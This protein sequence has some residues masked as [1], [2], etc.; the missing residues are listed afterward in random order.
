MK[1][2]KFN[3]LKIQKGSVTLYVVL[4]M[5]FFLIV[6]MGIYVNVNY[7]A[8]KQQRDIKKIEQSYNQVNMDELYEK[9]IQSI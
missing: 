8:Q 5:I 2:I 1:E 7:R 6:L 3:F 9:A 4:S